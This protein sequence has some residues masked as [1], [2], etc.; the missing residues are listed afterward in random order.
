[1]AFGGA[2]PAHAARVARILG[3]PEVIV[4][5]VSGVA[6]ALGFLVAPVSFDFSRSYPAEV[7]T[8]D[9][10]TVNGLYR[11]MEAQAKGVLAEAGIAEQ[12]M[13]LERRAEMR[14]AGQF[15]DLEVDVPNGLLSAENAENMVGVFEREYSR[16]Y[17]A[18]LPGYEPMV[19]NWRLRAL[20]TGTP[21][22]AAKR[23]ER[24]HARFTKCPQGNAPSL[25][26]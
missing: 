8:L 13:R 26:P 14:F 22:R 19:I 3:S 5:R 21:S 7:R 9:W 17:H 25:L 2:G 11:E 1:M 10:D 15:H 4:P 16:L 20:G 6:S 23:R 12:E 24:C 18:V